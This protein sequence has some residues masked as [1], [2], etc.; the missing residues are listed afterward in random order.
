MMALS[1]SSDA[2]FG[3]DSAVLS[4]DGKANLDRL[5]SRVQ[6]ASHIQD[7]MITG[8]TDRIGSDRYNLA[9]SQR[10]AEAVRDYLAANGVSATSMQVAGRG[11]ADPVVQ[12]DDKRREQLIA[13]LAPNR[14]VELKGTAKAPM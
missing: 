3:F 10:R 7:I 11:D 1:L 5:L 9:L 14:R 12:C 8:Y 13:C 4:A 6:E 2:L